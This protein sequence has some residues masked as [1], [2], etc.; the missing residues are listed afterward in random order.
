[1]S[2]TGRD[3][4]KLSLMTV[5][6]SLFEDPQGNNSAAG[7]GGLAYSPARGERNFIIKA[8]GADGAGKIN[9]DASTLLTIPGAQYDSVGQD[10]IHRISST[11]T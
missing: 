10:S 9:N 8:A 4:S 1:M 2:K 6:M 5:V 11:H 3:G 7:T